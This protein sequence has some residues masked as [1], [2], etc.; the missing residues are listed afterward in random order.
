MESI[1]VYRNPLEA[2]IWD[3]LMNGGFWVVIAFFLAAGAGVAVYGLIEKLVYGPYAWGKFNKFDARLMLYMHKGKISIAVSVLVL[4][5]F[6]VAN[7]N[8]VFS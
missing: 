4:Y 8:G 2:L 7:M 3:S 1:I 6:H 5:L